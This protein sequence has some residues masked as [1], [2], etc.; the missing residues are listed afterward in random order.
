MGT[1]TGSKHHSQEFKTFVA[2]QII[3]DGRKISEMSR[4]LDIPY[5]TLKNWVRDL[6][7][8]YQKAEKDRQ[9]QLL[10][11]TEYKELFE[12]ERKEKL[13]LLEE[14]EIIKKA[15]HIFTQEKL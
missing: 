10:T 1:G 15:M 11:A 9:E 7:N 8:E 4:T 14:N 6:R 12:K 13:E 3:Q 5:G 2:K